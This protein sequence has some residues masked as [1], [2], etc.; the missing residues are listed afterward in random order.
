MA[1][2]SKS[3]YLI[4]LLLFMMTIGLTACNQQAGP[5]A[6]ATLT[7]TAVVTPTPLPINSSYRTGAYPD[8]FT[9]LLVKSEEEVE[10]KLNEA[11]EQL[12]Y[13]NPSSQTHLTMSPIITSFGQNGRMK[14][15]RSGWMRPLRVAP[16]GKRPC[17]PTLACSLTMPNLMARPPITVQATTTKISA[18]MPGAMA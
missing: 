18:S 15:M 13:G 5:A 4:F 3:Q 7:A 8:L 1:I 2:S 12:F 10:A 16:S 9:D 14:I 17:S 11:W 6:A